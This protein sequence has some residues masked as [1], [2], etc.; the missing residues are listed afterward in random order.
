MSTLRISLLG[1]FRI[2]HDRHPVEIK[3]GHTLKGILAYLVLFSER[4]H[5]REV[6]AGLFWGDSTEDHA[7][8][9]LNTALWRLRKILEP[10][11][12]PKGTYLLTPS[13]GSMSQNLKLMLDRS[14]PNHTRP[15]SP[16]R[17][18]NWRMP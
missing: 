18:V 11:G 3:A 1:V 2:S 4:I 12:I 14:W 17:S 7:R 13:T 10:D 9:C 8:S 15:W 5:A 16:M 6:I